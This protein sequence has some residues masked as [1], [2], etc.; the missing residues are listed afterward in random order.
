MS[1]FW[2]DEN[3]NGSTCTYTV[4]DALRNCDCNGQVNECTYSEF[5]RTIAEER[6]SEW[7]GHQVVK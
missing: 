3:F 2:Y 7:A 6:S 1:C 4:G 5:G